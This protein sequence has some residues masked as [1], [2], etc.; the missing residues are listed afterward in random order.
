MLRGANLA[1]KFLLELAAFAALAYGGASL[2]S[3][4]VSLLPA[5]ALPGL[6]IGLW[7]VLAAP[8]SERRLAL[9]PRLTFELGVFGLAAAALLLAGSPLLAGGFAALVVLN[10]A[11]LAAWDQLEA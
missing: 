1:L 7:A 5:I 9:G 8:K 6:A 11:L 3:G 4:V 10:T 2:G